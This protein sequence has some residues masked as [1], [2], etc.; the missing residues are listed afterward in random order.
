MSQ[1]SKYFGFKIAVRYYTERHWDGV[2]AAEERK[3]RSP[4]SPR[5]SDLKRER[6]VRHVKDGPTAVGTS[7]HYSGAGRHRKSV[8]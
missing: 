8:L 5:R 4:A 3:S 2:A 7:A 1:L 6:M